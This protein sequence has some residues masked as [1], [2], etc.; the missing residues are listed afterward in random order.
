MTAPLNIPDGMEAVVT[1]VYPTQDEAIQAWEELVEDGY[2]FTG[3]WCYYKWFLN[4]IIGYDDTLPKM[5]SK[6]EMVERCKSKK[7]A[8]KKWLIK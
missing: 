7:K 6:V 2:W 8:K 3:E 1:F 5:T 4:F